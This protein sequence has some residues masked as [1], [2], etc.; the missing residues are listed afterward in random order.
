MEKDVHTEVLTLKCMYISCYR[1]TLVNQYPYPLC[2][3]LECSLFV[4]Q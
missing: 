2:L 3:L 4:K 1:V